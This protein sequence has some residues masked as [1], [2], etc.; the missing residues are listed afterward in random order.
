M[1]AQTRLPYRFLLDSLPEPGQTTTTVVTPQ[2]ASDYLEYAN[3]KVQRRVR[4]THVLDIKDRILEGKWISGV[5]PI[6]F[7]IASEE[8]AV[9]NINGQHTLRAIVE[10]DEPVKM[11]LRTYDRE[12]R[13][14]AAELFSF[15]DRQRKRSAKDNIQAFGLNEDFDLSQTKLG[16]ISSAVNLI[17]GD[18]NYRDGPGLRMGEH[19]VDVRTWA[20]YGEDYFRTVADVSHDLTDAF[21]RS[22]VLAVG[23]V[24]FRYCPKI[25]SDF[26][27]QVAW[28]DRI[29]HDDPRRTL[30]DFLLRYNLAG[31]SATEARQITKAKMARGIERA[32]NHFYRDGDEASLKVI[33]AGKK[34]RDL[35][36]KGTPWSKDSDLKKP[37]FAV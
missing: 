9:Y 36:L 37:E 32:W 27:Y 34:K 35:D 10:A 8:R 20:Q 29:R 11:D 28:C 16:T 25:A 7:V 1:K 17:R 24:T 30:Q 15:F 21:K 31:G 13:E 4:R 18:F 26:W 19:V 22:P 6:A 23:L 33:Q 12:T 3:F 5:Q 14:D 2:I